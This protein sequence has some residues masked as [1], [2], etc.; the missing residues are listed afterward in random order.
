V[1]S[2]RSHGCSL[3]NR[4]RHLDRHLLLAMRAHVLEVLC[5]SAV[6]LCMGC[7]HNIPA[8]CHLCVVYGG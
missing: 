1:D 6:A 5:L 3:P 8:L 7:H 4:A 2:R